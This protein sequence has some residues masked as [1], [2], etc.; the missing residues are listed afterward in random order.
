MAGDEIVRVYSK[1]AARYNITAHLYY[2]MGVRVDRYRKRTVAA[3]R[4]RRGDRVLDLACGT[5]ANFSWLEQAVGPQGHILGLDLTAAMLS[6][7]RKRIQ[8]NHWTNV[9]LLQADATNFTFP[10]PLDG[11]ICTYAISLMP[12]FA[13]VIQKSATALKDGGRM[14]ILDVRYT[15]GTSRFL[16]RVGDF[17]VKPFGSSDE[18]LRRRPW[19]EMP[20]Y[21]SSVQLTELYLGFLYIAVGTK[22]NRSKTQQGA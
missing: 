9:E 13:A 5:G 2:L 3:L 20:K 7:A 15:S 22:V 21:F 17:L 18:V 10:E 11:V 16:N 12:N 19:E 8:K 14:A 6:E 1:R 4:L